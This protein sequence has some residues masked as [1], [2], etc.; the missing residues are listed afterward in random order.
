VL[1]SGG[2]QAPVSGKRDD[3]VQASLIAK[4]F[5]NFHKPTVPDLLKQ[6]K[7]KSTVHIEEPRH[8]ATGGECVALLD[9]SATPLQNHGIKTSCGAR[10]RRHLKHQSQLEDLIEV[11]LGYRRHHEAAIG[12]HLDKA[13]YSEIAEGLTDRCCRHAEPICELTNRVQVIALDFAR[14]DSRANPPCRLASQAETF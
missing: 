7:M 6:L 14:D 8:V 11:F 1:A 12:N 4:P 10:H 13:I 2:V 3:P 9:E 5:D